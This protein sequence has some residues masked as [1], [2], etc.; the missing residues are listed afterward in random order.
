MCRALIAQ[1]G[2]GTHVAPGLVVGENAVEEERERLEEVD[3]RRHLASKRVPSAGVPGEKDIVG[4]AAER[5]ELADERSE[6]AVEKDVND[7]ESPSADLCRRWI[8]VQD[9]NDVAPEAAKE[10]AAE[11]PETLL[12]YR[13]VTAQEDKQQEEDD[14]NTAARDRNINCCRRPL[15]C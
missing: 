7:C 15:L 11:K 12:L 2:A 6:Q 8:R 4:S 5:G 9:R 1:G 13:P 10:E 14:L 3:D